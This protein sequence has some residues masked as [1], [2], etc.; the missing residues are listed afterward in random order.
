MLALL[1]IR[2]YYELIGIET[3]GIGTEVDKKTKGTE[4]QN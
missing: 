4:P 1:N 3:C 2:T